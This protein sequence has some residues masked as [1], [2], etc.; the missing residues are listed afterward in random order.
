MAVAAQ[1]DLSPDAVHST[2]QNIF[3]FN[4]FF[5]G[6]SYGLGRGFWFFPV[7]G[8]P[9]HADAATTHVCPTYRLLLAIVVVITDAPKSSG[10]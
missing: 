7:S 10:P 8:Q 3:F 9:V 6:E 4:N 2:K 5:S 1:I